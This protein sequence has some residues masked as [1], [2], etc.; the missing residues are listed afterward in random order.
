MKYIHPEERIVPIVTTDPYPNLIRSEF[1]SRLFAPLLGGVFLLR[2][3]GKPIC[4]MKNRGL[5]SV[6]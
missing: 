6:V 3:I 5:V 2:Q 4:L 1:P